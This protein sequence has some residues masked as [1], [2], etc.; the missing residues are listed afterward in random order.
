[1]NY[2]ENGGKCCIFNEDCITEMKKLTQEGYKVDCII[3]DPPYEISREN[4]FS[5]ME[6]RTGIDFGEWDKDVDHTSWL[7]YV[8]DITTDNASI[9]IFQDWKKLGIIA[10]ELEKVG[11]EV[12]DMLRWEKVNPMPR[13]RDRR[14]IVDFECAIWA[15]KK[16]SKWTFNRQD[17]KFQRP[18]FIYPIVSGKEK[19][20]HP[21]QKPISLMEDLIKIHTNENDIILDIFMGSGSTGVAALNLNRKFIGIELDKKY[22][23][24]AFDRISDCMKGGK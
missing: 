15:V 20:I 21:T 5:T 10:N 19:T 16:N 7:S 13:N 22:Y 12:K 4:N 8:Y 14:Y 6:N 3:T 23:D 1:M 2:F 24:I 9:I 11:F 18:K 17:D